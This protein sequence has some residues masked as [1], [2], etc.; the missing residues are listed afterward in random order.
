MADEVTETTEPEADN[1][2]VQG[3]EVQGA[4]TTQ[5]TD[6]AA[7]VGEEPQPPATDDDSAALWHQ[8]APE[9]ADHVN[10]L[11]P[12]AREGILLRKLA[13]QA[14]ERTRDPD[15][16]QGTGPKDKSAGD[17][18]SVLEIP[19]LSVDRMKAQLTDA[20][21]ADAA[22]VVAKSLAPT[23]DYVQKLAQASHA[24]IQ[25]NTGQLRELTVP[26]ELKRALPKVSL[27][28][29]GDIPAAAAVLKDG[30]A[31][32]YESALS[33]AA[34]R[35]MEATQRTQ[36]PISDDARR[37]AAGIAASSHASPQ[38]RASEPR[39][40]IPQG[41]EGYREVYRL[42]ARQQRASGGKK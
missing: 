29:E 20:F 36:R 32:T 30:L 18:P 3:Q 39:I 33:L 6:P 38:H 13:A 26:Q 35:R 8:V 22:E 28:T 21:G 14:A 37:K 19:E 1:G 31:T 23:L 7:P 42:Q 41:L 11:A 27:A 16:P 5:E 25:E 15:N 24:A 40:P 34:Y 10:D 2:E 4:E 9:L 17:R 12:E